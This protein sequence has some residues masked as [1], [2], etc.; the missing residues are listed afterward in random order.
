MIPLLL[1]LIAIIAYGL[2]TIN[3]ALILSQFVFHK[4][5][6]KYGSGNAG[7]TNFIRTFG[8]KW[9]MAVIGIDVLKSIIA[10]LFGGLLLSIPGDGFPVVG[11]LF[12]GFCLALGHMYPVQH[13]FRGGKGVVCCIVTLWM[14]DWRIGMVATIAFIGV[15]AFAQIMSLASLSACVVGVLA[16]WIFVPTDQLRGLAGT[17]VL[18][19]VLIILWRHWGN[20]IRLIEHREPKVRWGQKMDNRMRDDD[21]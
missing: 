5:V 2:G 15:L 10:V 9:G 19:M 6:R 3:G 16:T 17:L 18:F 21:F 12:A 8:P 7:Y 11:R 4:D 20:I 14:A 13:Q 1:I